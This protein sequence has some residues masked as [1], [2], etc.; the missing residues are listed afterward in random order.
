MK[1]HW[2]MLDETLHKDP[3]HRH[4][5]FAAKPSV[6]LHSREADT[7]ETEAA[8]GEFDYLRGIR[9]RSAAA[10]FRFRDGISMFFVTV[11]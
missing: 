2:T 6:I 5:S 10:E 11:S 9:D 7:A 8:C 1:E 4:P 3:L